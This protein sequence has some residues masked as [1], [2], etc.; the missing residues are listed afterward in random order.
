MERHFGRIG[1]QIM[2]ERRAR[3]QQ[4]RVHAKQHGKAVPSYEELSRMARSMKCFCGV[5]M[6]WTSKEDKRR[7]VTLQ[8]DRSGKMRLLC[9]SCNTRH[10]FHEGDH[11]YQVPTG[12]KWCGGCREYR[13]LSLF[14]KSKDRTTGVSAYC[15][16]CRSEK[17]R[18]LIANN[19]AAYNEK[20][21][22]YYHARIASGNPIPR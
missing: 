9:R 17:H 16:P 14:C 8:H 7:V 18:V 4:M 11:F 3:F 13:A 5:Q 19:K 21:R 2:S 15:R 12:K 10:A 1:G 6:V 20:R 22:A